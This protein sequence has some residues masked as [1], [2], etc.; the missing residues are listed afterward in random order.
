M[1]IV[2]LAVTGH[3]FTV[4]EKT[5]VRSPLASIEREESVLYKVGEALIVRLESV[6]GPALRSHPFAD[7]SDGILITGRALR[8]AGLLMV[9]YVFIFALVSSVLLGRRELAFS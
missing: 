4:G 6:A 1:S 5:D 3:S 2:F 9:L 8:E 7:L